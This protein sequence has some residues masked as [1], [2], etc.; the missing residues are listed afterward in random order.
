MHAALAEVRFVFCSALKIHLNSMMVMLVSSGFVFE[1]IIACSNEMLAEMYKPHNK[2]K[3]ACMYARVACMESV[4]VKC[5][6]TS[7]VPLT[8]SEVSHNALCLLSAFGCKATFYSLVG[9]PAVN[10]AIFS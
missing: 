8:L 9:L 7:I 2:G 3:Q 10:K 5:P 4:K 1:R 6:L